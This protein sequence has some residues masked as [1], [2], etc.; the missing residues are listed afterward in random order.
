M[1]NASSMIF[2]VRPNY[3]SKIYTRLSV[4]HLKAEEWYDRLWL[5]VDDDGRLLPDAREW[6]A[7]LPLHFGEKGGPPP[8]IGICGHHGMAPDEVMAVTE[9]M[10]ETLSALDPEAFDFVELPNVTGDAVDPSRKWWFAHPRVFASA[11]N[12]EVSRLK[13]LPPGRRGFARAQLR[14]SRRVFYADKVPPRAYWIEEAVGYGMA[15]QAF[16]DAIEPLAGDLHVWR[17]CEVG[18]S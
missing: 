8:E 14:G 18:S 11:Y 16:R 2:A 4:P 1:T 5:R 6:V 7:G 13:V 17:P 9:T 12:L 3:A 10:R 15:T